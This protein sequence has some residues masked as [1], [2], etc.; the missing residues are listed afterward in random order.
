[1]RRLFG[2]MWFRLALSGLIAGL[3]LAWVMSH[4]GPPYWK[5]EPR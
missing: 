2:K 3:I 1:M 4:G 5:G